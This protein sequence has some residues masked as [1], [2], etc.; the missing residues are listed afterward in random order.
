MSEG[1]SAG[2]EAQKR[3]EFQD[4]ALPHLDA[5]YRF[6]LRLTGSPPAAEDLVQDTYFRAW[7]AW[8]QYT[9]GTNCK[10]WLF[11]ICRNAFLRNR[12]RSKRHDEILTER[13]PD[14]PETLSRENPV[15]A[16]SRDE[17]PE[18]DFFRELVD[19]E[20]LDAI[21]ELPEEYR[22]AVVLSDLEGLAY[23]EVAELM[24]VPVGTVKSRLFRGR[25]M[26]QEALYE[27]AVSM[28]YIAPKGED[29]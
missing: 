7:R 26:L 18:G 1:E 10:S 5:V 21:D 3:R 22:T 14:D 17:D 2:T 13:A 4:E 19:D 20:V 12:E 25:R 15:F 11:T 27:Y 9:L 23:K 16:A 8:N 24:D 6:A 29:E 28:G